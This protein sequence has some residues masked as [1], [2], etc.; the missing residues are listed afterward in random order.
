[1]LVLVLYG[2][3]QTSWTNSIYWYNTWISSP[4][5]ILYKHLNIFYDVSNLLNLLPKMEPEACSL[6][7]EWMIK[8]WLTHFH[9]WAC[10]SWPVLQTISAFEPTWRKISLYISKYSKS[11]SIAV[12]DSHRN[13]SKLKIEFWI[14]GSN[15][16]AIDLL[17]QRHTVH[18]KWHILVLNEFMDHFI[19]KQ[20]A[21]AVKLV[22][23]IE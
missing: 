2:L 10:S 23:F 12:A 14:F 6:I 13:I 5:Y 21:V 19:K 17:L 20:L 22:E 15:I 16:I 8:N 11:H 1:M 7:Y 4:P 9:K 3:P 18:C